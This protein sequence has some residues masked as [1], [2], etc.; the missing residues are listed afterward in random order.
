[1]QPLLENHS[2]MEELLN[3]IETRKPTSQLTTFTVVSRIACPYR[4]K[5]LTLSWFKF[6]SFL[7]LTRTSITS[8]SLHS[9]RD[10]ARVSDF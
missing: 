8:T 9:Q 10:V 4:N 5:W 2:T 1:M 7:A 6:F 3:L